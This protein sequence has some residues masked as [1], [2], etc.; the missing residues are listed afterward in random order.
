MKQ[1]NLTRGKVAL[2]DDEDFEWLNQWKWKCSTFGYAVRLLPADESGKRS[3]VFMHRL[4]L[5][6]PS[7][8]Y[9]DHINQ[10]K[11]D[12]RKA[13][14]RIATKSQNSANSK[15][16]VSGKTASFK[17]VSLKQRGVFEA[18]IKTGG[19]YVYLGRFDTEEDAALAYNDAAKKAFGEFA[20]LNKIQSELETDE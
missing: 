5:G 11:L 18:Q 16:R 3:N 6:T 4:I 8:L 13:N 14:L 1:I 7:G 19:K 12:N 17:G 9:T 15:V 2:V 20:S 10:D